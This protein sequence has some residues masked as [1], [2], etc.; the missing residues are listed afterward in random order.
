[1]MQRPI[2]VGQCA[3]ATGCT[4]APAWSRRVDAGR[5]S[6]E[7]PRHKKDASWQQSSAARDAVTPALQLRRTVSSTRPRHLQGRLRRKQAVTA[8][9]A[10]GGGRSNDEAWLTGSAPWDA[11]GLPRG[12]TEVEIKAAFRSKVSR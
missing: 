6:P 1:M 7:V 10:A 11:L 3:L 9:R 4:C 5:H 2:P 12:A 8:A